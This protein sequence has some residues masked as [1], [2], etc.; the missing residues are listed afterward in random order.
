MRITIASILTMIIF[1]GCGRG[2]KAEFP[3]GDCITVDATK[4]NLDNNILLSMSDFVDKV[5]II[6]LEFNKDCILSEIRKIVIHNNN[7]F[8]IE[9]GGPKTIY[10]FDTQGNFLNKIG[11]HGQGPQEFIEL[12]DF[13]L[14]ENDQIVYL[15]D[16]AKQAILCF[17]FD[18]QFIERI[19]INQYASRLEYKDGLFYLFSDNPPVG[20]DLYNLTVRNMKG[21]IEKM[22]FASKGYSRGFSRNTFTKTQDNLFFKQ[23]MSDTIC[24]LDET[25]LKNAFFFDFGSYRFT[26]DEIE[27]LYLGKIRTQQLLLNKE[28]LSG[29]DNFFNVGKWIYFNSTYK[30]LSFSF[31]YNTNSQELKVAAG[32]QD[33]VEYLFYNNKFYGQTQDAFIGVY[34]VNYLIS[35]IDRFSKHEKEK[36]I[37]SDKK[38]EQEKKIKDIMR[39]NNPEE[40]NPWVILYYLKQD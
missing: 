21:E 23:P 7:L 11:S 5:D 19:R 33:D 17:D 3:T 29:I 12:F 1:F 31:L 4:I 35:N 36:I 6:P 37:S 20:D 15:L 28:R 34:D 13:S 16:N 2:N 32:I 14:N 25:S 30:V 40:M 27:E 9:S 10:R 18:G 8:L 22:Y 39:G 24:S 38:E 26:S